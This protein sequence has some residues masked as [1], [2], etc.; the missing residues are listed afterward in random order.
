MTGRNLGNPDDAI[1]AFADALERALSCP[2]GLFTAATEAEMDRALH[3]VRAI[4]ASH[5]AI[6]EME[7]VAVQVRVMREA[8]RSGRVNFYFSQLLRLQRTFVPAATASAEPAL[9]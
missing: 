6:G 1:A 8:R 7:R 3:A 9:A 5:A 2:T 4:D